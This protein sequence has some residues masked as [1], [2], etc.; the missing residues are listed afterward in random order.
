LKSV[1]H[2]QRPSDTSGDGLDLM[3]DNLTSLVENVKTKADE[4]ME[5]LKKQKDFMQSLAKVYTTCY[6]S[7]ASKFFD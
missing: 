5:Y 4:R 1:R 7:H 6:T 3:A 2:Y